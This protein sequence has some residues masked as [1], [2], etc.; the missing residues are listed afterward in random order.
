MKIRTMKFGFKTVIFL[1]VSPLL[2][3][4][5]WL[6]VRMLVFDYFT[7]PT[8]SMCPTL[9][10]GDKVIV[11]KLIVGARI[12][13]DLD[14]DLNG[15]ELKSF[16]LK[17]RRRIRHNDI[18]VFNM[19][20]HNGKLNFIINNV[21][22]KRVIGLPGDSV[23]ATEGHYYNNNYDGELGISLEQDHLAQIPDSM[24]TWGF[25]LPPH[26]DSGWN[27]KNFG[28]LYI[29]RRGDVV[30]ITAKEAVLYQLLLEWELNKNITWDW[31]KNTAFADGKP[32][33]RHRF[34]H[35]YYFMA[36]DNAKNSSD[37]RYWGLVPEEYVV[38]VVDKVIRD[39]KIFNPN[40]D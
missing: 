16:R 35:D 10:P 17:G 28:P 4:G 38:G 20:N 8:Q 23:G 36:G 21:Y 6:T 32:L 11:N 34:C 24:I 26:H 31:E 15:Q 39:H 27:L 5:A 13:T 25:W 40:E 19:T 22:C 29:P 12:Y 3:Y 30:G 2:L 7:I 14:F 1:V 18:V 9:L 33:K 37:S